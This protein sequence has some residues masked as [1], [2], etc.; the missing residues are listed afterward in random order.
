MRSTMSDV[1]LRWLI[2]LLAFSAVLYQQYHL[3]ALDDGMTH[4]HSQIPT[5]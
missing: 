5:V 3:W 1:I 4:V 2:A